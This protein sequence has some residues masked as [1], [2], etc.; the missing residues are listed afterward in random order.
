MDEIKK[1]R[2]VCE[3]Y[4]LRINSGTDP[5]GGDGGDRPSGSRR[6]LFNVTIS[7]VNRDLFN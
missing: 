6:G 7:R 1:K 4:K 2:S 3:H 5:E